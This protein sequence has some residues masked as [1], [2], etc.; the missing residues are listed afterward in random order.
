MICREPVAVAIAAILSV[1]YAV[2]H[3]WPKPDLC[4]VQINE[5]PFVAKWVECDEEFQVKDIESALLLAK[6]REI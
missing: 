6:G 3:F 4:Y 5:D 2:D 1:V